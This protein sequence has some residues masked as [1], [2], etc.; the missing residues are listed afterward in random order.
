MST[1][2]MNYE[3][4]HVLRALAC[5]LVVLS[6]ATGPHFS[7]TQL[8][9]VWQ[10]DVFYRAVI[11]IAVPLFLMISGYLLLDKKEDILVFYKK[12]SRRIVPPFVFYFLAYY[13]AVCLFYK[14]VM[15][16]DSFFAF[17]GQGGTVHMW[18]LFTLIGIYAFMPYLR[19]VFQNSTVKE[20]S[21]FIA[22]WFFVSSLAPAFFGYYTIDYDV[23]E[24]LALYQ[25]FGYMGFVFMGGCAKLIH[26]GPGSRKIWLGIWACCTIATM[27]IT[28]S[29][30]Y[31][32]GHPYRLF[33]SRL[34]PLVVLATVSFF[35]ALKDV[36]LGKGMGWVADISACAFGIYLV[37]IFVIRALSLAHI[38]GEY[39][40][41]W[42]TQPFAGAL[43]LVV[44]YYIVKFGKT[45]PYVRRV[46]G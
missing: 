32:L 28:Y 4:M 15:N 25:F 30:S 22:F 35:F 46:I 31:E 21:L 11:R 33:L 10:A 20:K 12:R 9:V 45:I 6:H 16:G 40:W 19:M 2:K 5:C 24:R 42:F 44:S 37:H 27:A 14:R 38:G 34:A 8:D 39:G 41:S 7:W 36:R 1:E 13:V 26:V 18:Y 29:K 43:A 17:L 3:G 23:A